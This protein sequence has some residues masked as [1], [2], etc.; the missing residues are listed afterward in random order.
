MATITTRAGKGSPLTNTEVDDNFS[1]LNSAK[2][3]SGSAGSLSTLATADGSAFDLVALTLKNNGT[4]SSNAHK[5][6]ID[7]KVNYGTTDAPPRAR[8]LASK[9]VNNG[10]K[11]SLELQVLNGGALQ[12]RQVWDHTGTTINEDS[13]DVDFR[14]ESNDSA[15][16]LVVDAAEN[17][18]GIN[19]TPNISNSKLEVGGADDV[20]LINVE[21]SGVTG[22]I[23]IG[24]GGLKL[25]HGSSP[26]LTLASNGVA[27]FTSGITAGGTFT[28]SGAISLRRD[29]AGDGSYGHDISFLN[30]Y[31]E[32][33]DDRVALI[34]VANQG[35][36][37]TTR[38]GKFI[39]YTRQS[40]S[41]NFNS[42][43]TIDKDGNSTFSG[44][45]V[46]NSTN[47]TADFRVEGDSQTHALFLNAANNRVGI[48][49]DTPSYPLDVNGGGRFRGTLKLGDTASTAG[50]LAICDTS[51][52]DYTLNLKGVGTRGYVME[53]SASTANYNLTMQNSGS[54]LFG[55]TV[56]GYGSF[57]QT[58]DTGA[59]VT[60]G[61]HQDGKL[62]NFQS[63]GSTR[64]YL[65]GQGTGDDYLDFRQSND[66]SHLRMYDNEGVVI[67]ETGNAADFRVESDANTHG[68]F[69]DSSTDSVGICEDYM[70]GTLNVSGPGRSFSNGTLYDG[71]ADGAGGIGTAGV[72]H[73][74]LI[75]KS[76]TA[77]AQDMGASIALRARSGNTLDDVTYGIIGAAKENSVDDGSNS[78]ND[79]SRGYLS[80]HVSEG[81]NFG[82]QYGTRLRQR[83]K[84]GSNGALTAYP[85]VAGHAVFNE[86]GVNADFRVE[87]DGNANM[88]V[89]DAALN[90]VFIGGTATGQNVVH[91]DAGRI[92]LDKSN[93][94]NIESGGSS[95]GSHI[96]F[97][98]SSADVGSI[99]STSSGTTYSTT[100]DR[101]LKKDIET[102]TDG[103][104]KLMAMNPVTHGWK[105][106]P[107]GDEVHGFIAQEM[108][109]IVPEAVSGDPEGD[110]M[111]SMDYGRITPV[112]VA[113]LQDAH[114]KIAQLEARLDKVET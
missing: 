111:M 29:S 83:M 49:E 41:A 14:V 26:K 109:D 75:I 58:V 19:R 32:G 53:G 68:L 69:L 90:T 67:N 80:F 25:F 11:G 94:W 103:T 48:H 24:S 3:E 85:S 21:A 64:F 70:R 18:V 38:G 97:R 51:S 43:L 55:L 79:Q 100:S 45:A 13:L 78:Y 72:G 92:M 96:R 93:D 66:Q 106:D 47:S 77:E 81:Y 114:R 28:N 16:M 108:M 35:G 113:A 74:T 7:F 17:K 2:Y 107:D 27:T 42:A 37:G 65:W 33:S 30:S 84:I 88:L 102:I 5:V 104:D 4:A 9:V 1:N 87:S 71:Y 12:E 56:Y 40:G 59:T 82:P 89:V 20:P 99:T 34:R 54:G 10:N 91:L 6:L 23:G 15:N 36:D 73:S 62:I 57:R 86:D 60:I 95:N 44:G 22:G 61:G 105:A 52:T 63:G 76:T 101:R 50:A 98:Q 39:F 112:L 46:V 31:A 8:L 110:E